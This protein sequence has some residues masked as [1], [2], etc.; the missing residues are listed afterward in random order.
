MCV[1][2]YTD[3]HMNTY[4]KYCQ[5]TLVVVVP[6]YTPIHQGYLSVSISPCPY[7]HVFLNAF[8]ILANLS[9]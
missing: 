9:F 5:I 6:I 7:Q 1:C 2:V 8:I 4:C 3:T